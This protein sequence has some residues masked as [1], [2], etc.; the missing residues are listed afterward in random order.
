MEDKILTKEQLGM[1][2]QSKINEGLSASE[3]GVWAFGFKLSD[4]EWDDDILS[5]VLLGLDG[6]EIGPDFQYSQKALE[7][8]AKFLIN[9]DSLKDDKQF[10]L[11][12]DIGFI[13][14][15]ASDRIKNDREAVLAAIKYNRNVLRYASDEMK[16]DREIVIAAVKNW[17]LALQYA[18]K[19]LRA[20][21]EIVLAAMKQNSLAFKYADEALKT[22]KDILLETQR[23]E[24]HSGG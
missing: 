2:L 14:E 3:I 24:E 19:N 4:F 13:F 20:D 8:L 16:N 18:S 5:D 9:Y 21:K 22:D 10:F 7:S 11:D 23:H 17:G 1:D 12:N 15:Y 6:M